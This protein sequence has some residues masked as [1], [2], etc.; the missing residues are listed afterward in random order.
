MP[1]GGAASTI[2][3]NVKT[4]LVIDDIASL[5]RAFKRYFE[6]WVPLDGR[7]EYETWK[8]I[9]AGTGDEAIGALV[10][11][12]ADPVDLVFQDYVMPGGGE[13]LLARIR[14]VAPGVPV[15]LMTGLPLRYVEA[16][17]WDDVMPKPFEMNDEVVA[18]I[19][20]LIAAA[21]GPR[22]PPQ[23]GLR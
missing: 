20:A 13:R 14:E 11:C 16:E 21:S 15:V 9:E 12:A 22:G 6:S 8:V 2:P 23:T 18:R 10:L 1:C 7:A 17:K 4:L 19:E 3:R 5:R